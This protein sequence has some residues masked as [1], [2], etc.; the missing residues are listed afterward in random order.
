MP[1]INGGHFSFESKK[2]LETS[3]SLRAVDSLGKFLD[4]LLVECRYVV[5]FSTRDEAFVDDHLFVHPISAGIDQVC[6]HGWPRRDLSTFNDACFDQRPRPMADHRDRLA[7]VKKFL[8]EI[9][10]LGL[11]PELVGVSDAARQQQSVKI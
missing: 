10:R 4:H 9:D 5:R 11:H 2:S 3:S 8:D 7:G 1:A 6:F